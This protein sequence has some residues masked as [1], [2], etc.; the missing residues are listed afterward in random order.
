MID[1]WID[2]I[3][4]KSDLMDE[5][6][7]YYQKFNPKDSIKLIITELE[8]RKEKQLNSYS[9]PLIEYLREQDPN[10]YVGALAIQLYLGQNTIFYDFKIPE[11]KNKAEEEL[12]IFIARDGL[13]NETASKWG[14]IF[15]EKYRIFVEKNTLKQDLI[16]IIEHRE[17]I[18][19]SMCQDVLN[20][21]DFL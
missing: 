8:Q 17:F 2:H 1:K 12:F 6:R 18:Y 3:E 5:Q 10:Q 9:G 7:Q 21:K 13:I 11:A 15:S 20:F 14:E 16:R 19:N 4:K